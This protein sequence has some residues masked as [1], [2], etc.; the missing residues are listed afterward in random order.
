M[1]INEIEL[2]EEIEKLNGKNI[3]VLFYELLQAKL[4]MSNVKISYNIENGFLKIRDNRQNNI[5]INIVSV[6]QI[7]KS[8]SSIYMQLDNGINIKIKQN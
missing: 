2:K 1:N 5:C 3:T 8:S 7:E 6:Y 4:K